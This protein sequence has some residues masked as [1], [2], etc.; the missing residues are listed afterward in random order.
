MTQ[1]DPR[2]AVVRVV[3]KAGTT[4]GTGFLVT[5]DGLVVTCAHVVAGAGSGPNGIVEVRFVLAGQPSTARVL[6]DLWRDPDAEDVALLQLV[7]AVPGEAEPLILRRARGSAGNRF[8]TYGFP[9]VLSASGLYGY[10]VVGDLITDPAGVPL[11]QLTGTTETSQ[12]F[13]GGP[14]IDQ[15][16]ERVVGM[17][18]SITPADRHGRLVQTAFATPTETLRHI[19]PRLQVS[20]ECPYRSLDVFDVDHARFFFGRER[21]VD[22]L[23]T[24]VAAQP[25]VLAVLGPSG[26]GKSSVLR[27]G[28]IARLRDNALA[29]S[30]TWTITVTRPS[31]IGSTPDALDATGGAAGVRT[32]LVIDQFEEVFSFDSASIQL[33]GDALTRLAASTAPLTVVLAMRDDFYSHLARELPAFMNAW[34]VP[35]LVNIPATLETD[36]LGRIISRPADQVGLQLED[37]LVDAIVD[38]A[39]EASPVGQIRAALLPLIEFALTQL[40]QLQD[41]GL[42]RRDTFRDI[43]GVAGSLARWADASYY[44]LAPEAQPIARRII[45][46]LTRL[47]DEVTGTPDNRRRRLVEQLMGVAPEDDVR[48]VMGRLVTARLLVT[49][50]D[51]RTGEMWVELIHDALLREWQLLRGWLHE[52]RQ[53]LAWR[54]SLDYRIGSWSEDTSVAAD[55][56]DWLRGRELEQ[57]AQYLQ[58]RG[59]DLDRRQRAFIDGSV[60]ARRREQERERA[61]QEQAEAQRA[62]AE[63]QRQIAETHGR[64]ERLRAETENARALVPLDPAVALASALAAAGEAM[65]EPGAPPFAFVRSTLFSNVRAVKERRVFFGHQHA[66]SAVAFD[67]RGRWIVSGSPDRNVL[68]WSLDPSVP[69][70]FVGS[71]EA[72]V[73]SVAVSPDGATIASAGADLVVRRW[74]PQGLAAGHP[75]T[76]P[77]DSVLDVAFSPDGGTVA[78]A[79]ADGYVYLWPASG[80]VP[81]R[82]PHP[83]YVASVDF[84]PDGATLLTGC[85]DGS[86]WL[87]SAAGDGEG[88]PVARAQGEDFVTCARFSPDGSLFAAAGREGTVHV[89]DNEARELAVLALP[90]HTGLVTSLGFGPDGSALVTA[91]EDGSVRLWDLSGRPVHAPLLC[92]DGP[93]SC[94][95]VSGDGR[96][97]AGGGGASVY[98]WDWLPL[99]PAPVGRTGTATRSIPR[100]DRAGDQAGPAWIGHEEFVAA[101][102]FTSDGTGVVS[103]GGDRSLR[104]WNLD[105]SVRAVVPD[106]HD[107][108]ITTVACSPSGFPLIASGGRDNMVRLFDGDG[109]RLGVTAAGHTA[110]VMA[111]AFSP[112]ARLLASGS[113]DGTVR[114]WTVDGRPHGGPLTGHEGEVLTVAFSPLGALL[115]SAGGD[116]TVRLWSLDGRPLGRPI[117]AHADLVWD[118][119]FSPDGGTIV[120]AGGDL[121]VRLWTADGQPIGVPLQGHTR[122]VRA[123]A[124][125]PDGQM[126]VTAGEDGTLRTWDA[127]A[128]QLTRPLE[129]HQGSVFALAI[130]PDGELAVSG[131][132]DGTVRLWR[133]GN[134][135]AWLLEGCRRLEHHPLLD[136][137]DPLAQ[138]VRGA[139]QP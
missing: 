123:V 1:G 139:C 98:L 134:W 132:Q 83:S 85:G 24:A 6:P 61:L 37:G 3:D 71:H 20:A 35:N 9:E 65:T 45:T 129:G 29:G 15:V 113:R 95:A 118:L 50:R 136:S 16:S 38:S 5:A 80:G 89:W 135:R 8:S 124:F 41:D 72:D 128:G 28:L 131:G 96:W 81:T 27:A 56:A 87:W 33:W 78:G 67:A 73:L 57:A 94:V 114:L 133:L 63:R 137:D 23:V 17:V 22:K 116:G 42:L 31:E 112:D 119:A 52:D 30:S 43:G 25:R 126:M 19:C 47:G 117:Y 58:A 86:V 21:L 66:V 79:C 115:A 111:V 103:A 92:P 12:G 36:D 75:L 101:V 88:E 51:E 105:G 122:D 13:S 44:A 77:T 107:G 127:H 34:V 93:S 64:I 100:W 99:R 84:S 48:Q 39:R 108:G 68:L 97:I 82:L 76:G 62:E 69:N 130:S 121:T 11:L 120:S 60:A 7:D 4:A 32:L 26:S 53:F 14:V 40:W 90:G 46:S 110:D 91:G 109:R 55:D 102:A 10:G 49:Q 54:Q 125:H 104:L 2:A 18:S 59:D 70:T 74:R 106:A 138:A